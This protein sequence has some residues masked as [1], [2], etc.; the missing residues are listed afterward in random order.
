MMHVRI[1][2]AASRVRF[3]RQ[4]EPVHFGDQG[5]PGHPEP[6]R[7]TIPSA[8]D[9]VGLTKGRR[10]VRPLGIGQRPNDGHDG[11]RRRFCS[12]RPQRSTRSHN[13]RPLDDD[14]QLPDT[15]SYQLSE[16]D[17]NALVAYI[18]R[19]QSPMSVHR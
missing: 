11:S 8:N 15:A 10:N 9:P 19:E 5:R 17:L 2:V 1:P 3:P 7:G 16:E 4:T 14:L 12:W 6:S 18:D 13:H